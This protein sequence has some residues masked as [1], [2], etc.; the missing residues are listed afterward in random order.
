[1]CV[2]VCLC[3]CGGCGRVVRYDVELLH[4]PEMLHG[5]MAS[6]ALV[7]MHAPHRRHVHSLR[8]LQWSFGMFNQRTM[9]SSGYQVHTLGPRDSPEPP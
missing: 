1:M 8:T 2:Y 4:S 9:S 7:H 6:L 5:L 3:V